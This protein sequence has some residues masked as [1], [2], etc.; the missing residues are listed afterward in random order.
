MTFEL[1]VPN[2][3]DGAIHVALRSQLENHASTLRV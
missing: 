3:L 1:S 2:L